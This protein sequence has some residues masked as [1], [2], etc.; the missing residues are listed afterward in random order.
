MS[1]YTFSC[2][3][4]LYRGTGLTYWPTG[5]W[6]SSMF[7]HV[8]IPALAL[9]PKYIQYQ[10]DSV[11]RMRRTSRTGAAPGGPACVLVG[12]VY[13]S[14]C[15]S[16]PG[17]VSVCVVGIVDWYHSWNLSLPHCNVTR[18]RPPAPR[19][20]V[21]VHVHSSPVNSCQSHHSP[22]PLDY[23]PLFFLLF[24]TSPL[25][26]SAFFMFPDYCCFSISWPFLPHNQFAQHA[27]YLLVSLS[28]NCLRIQ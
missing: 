16:T 11:H 26:V 9:N 23:L 13:A 25:F 20:Q 1:L 18:P 24:L 19:L 27:H 14:T 5:Q 3:L 12:C 28:C 2:S 6:C 4:R 8:G 17:C 7:T 21:H 22:P 10:A 15:M